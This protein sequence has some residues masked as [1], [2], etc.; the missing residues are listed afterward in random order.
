MTRA[1]R[2]SQAPKEEHLLLMIITKDG[3][4]FSNLTLLTLPTFSFELSL[5]LARP[6][7]KRQLSFGRTQY[8]EGRWYASIGYDM[9]CKYLLSTGCLNRVLVLLFSH[10]S[11]FSLSLS[12]PIASQ[13]KFKVLYTPPLVL[14]SI[15]ISTFK[16]CKVSAAHLGLYRCVKSDQSQVTRSCCSSIYCRI[17]R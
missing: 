9:T 14:T 8:R 6:C 11:P 10:P 16:Q 7:F 13:N 2:F 17:E 3:S 5:T 12:V 1:Y 4:C 15:S